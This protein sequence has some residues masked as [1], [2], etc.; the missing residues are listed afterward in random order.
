VVAEGPTQTGGS[1][2]IAGVLG[3]AATWVV[4]TGHAAVGV[5]RCGGCTRCE[6]VGAVCARSP[7]VVDRSFWGRAALQGR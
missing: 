3:A 7:Q 1:Y 6:G 5:L 4:P 2:D